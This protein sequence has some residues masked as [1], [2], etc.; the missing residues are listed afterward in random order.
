MSVV[1]PIRHPCPPGACVCDQEQLLADA[2]ADRRILHLTRD[3]EKRLLARLEAIQS[4]ADLQHM[5]QRMQE[6]LGISMIIAPSAR[7]V[8]TIS[9]ISIRLEEQRG[10]CRK[11]REAIPAAIRRC[12]KNN[13]T[14]AFAILD[15]HDLLRPTQ[16]ALSEDDSS[17]YSR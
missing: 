1:I 3:E 15:A 8:R 14:I 10:L 7:G 17:D 16:A 4:Y 2:N 12:L 5:R 13:E 6:Q 9:G 11:T